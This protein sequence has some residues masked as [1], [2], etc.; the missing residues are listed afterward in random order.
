MSSSVA[1]TPSTNESS[2][3]SIYPQNGELSMRLAYAPSAKTGTV[4]AV[5]PATEAASP[6]MTHRH[7]EY[8]AAA[9][10]FHRTIRRFWQRSAIRA[11]LSSVVR[12]VIHKS[13]LIQN[14]PEPRLAAMDKV[15][16]LSLCFVQHQTGVPV[17]HIFKI[18]KIQRLTAPRG[19]PASASITPGAAALPVRSAASRRPHCLRCAAPRAAR[20]TVRQ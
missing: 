11:H 10:R 12:I 1:Q 8:S 7:S 13:I 15:R 19:T 6:S 20:Q 2:A 4:R 18:N 14:Y 5:I 16:D 17:A 3:M 9:L